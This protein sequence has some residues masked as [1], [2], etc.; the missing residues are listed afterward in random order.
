MT[1]SLRGK[2]TEEGIIHEIKKRTHPLFIG[3]PYLQVHQAE[4]KD[5]EFSRQPPSGS[6]GFT[7]S[8]SA[9]QSYGIPPIIS[10]IVASSQ[11]YADL[12]NG[13]QNPR[14]LQLLEYPHLSHTKESDRSDEPLCITDEVITVCNRRIMGVR[15]LDICKCVE[16]HSKSTRH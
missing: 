11:S 1:Q 12:G 13:Y 14:S 7:Q 9:V 15:S 8:C 6:T 4:R 10:L 5:L 16:L 2:V 3:E